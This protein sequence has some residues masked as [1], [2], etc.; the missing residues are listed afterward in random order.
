M[1]PLLMV[2]IRYILYDSAEPAGF[3]PAPFGRGPTGSATAP[4]TK[5][6]VRANSLE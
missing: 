6:F 2:L 3:E 1:N 5:P 4:T